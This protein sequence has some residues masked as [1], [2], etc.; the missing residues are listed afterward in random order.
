MLLMFRP[1]KVGD[2]V[3]IGGIT[4]SVVAVHIFSTVMKTADNIMITV[5]NCPGLGWHDQELQRFRHPP[6]RSGDGHQL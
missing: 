2:V 6:D 4:G 1:F 3:E 5:P